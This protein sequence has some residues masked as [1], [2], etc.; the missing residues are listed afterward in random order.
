MSGAIHRASI[1]F[2]AVSPSTGNVVTG[3]ADKELKV[4]DL[5][6][7]DQLKPVISAQATDAI[8]YGE[9]LDGGNLCITGCGDG[10]I[11]AFDL[12]RGGECLY[13]YGCD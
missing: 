3:A 1:N 4:F 5:R 13:G 10:N 9:L 7:S 6:G 8:F 2:L 12:Q 11:L